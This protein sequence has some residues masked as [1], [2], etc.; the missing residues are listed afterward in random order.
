[1]TDWSNFL[2]GVKRAAK[3]D[4]RPR[5]GP[6]ASSMGTG[7]PPFSAGITPWDSTICLFP[8]MSKTDSPTSALPRLHLSGQPL[9]AVLLRRSLCL[10]HTDYQEASHEANRIAF[11]QEKGFDAAQSRC[12]LSSGVLF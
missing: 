3:E 4:F 6:P 2:F 12:Y 9:R 11:P 1:M 7:H 10:V 8:S 5:S